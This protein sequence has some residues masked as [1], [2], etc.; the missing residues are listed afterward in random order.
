M[1]NITYEKVLSAEVG[2]HSIE[3]DKTGM[4]EVS[5]SYANDSVLKATVNDL[6]EENHEISEYTIKEYDEHGAAIH[7]QI[8]ASYPDGVL[9]V[10]KTYPKLYFRIFRHIDGGDEELVKTIGEDHVKAFCRGEKS[11]ADE[12]GVMSFSHLLANEQALTINIS[13]LPQKYD[14]EHEYTYVIKE[15][16]PTNQTNGND[17]IIQETYIDNGKVYLT[18]KKNNIPECKDMYFKVMRDNNAVKK[19]VTGTKELTASKFTISKTELEGDFLKATGDNDVS[20]TNTLETIDV[21]VAKS[22]DDNG[23]GVESDT[24]KVSETSEKLHY[25]VKVTLSGDNITI[26][27]T[28]TN[29]KIIGIKDKDSNLRFESLPKYVDENTLAVY[30]VKEDA[31]NDNA[32]YGQISN[33]YKNEG[34]TTTLFTRSSYRYG[35]EGSCKLKTETNGNMQFNILNTLPLTAVKVQKHWD[36]QNNQFKLRPSNINDKNKGENTADSIYL[37]LSKKINSESNYADLKPTEIVGTNAHEAEFKDWYKSESNIPSSGNEWTYTYKKLLKYDINNN[38]YTFQITED[39]VPAYKEPHYCAVSDYNDDSKKTEK[40]KVTSVE[41]NN[42][43]SSV[44]AKQLAWDGTNPLVEA[45]EITNKLDT[46]NVRV[47]KKWEDNGYENGNNLHYNVKITLSSTDITMLAGGNYSENKVIANTDKNGV[48]FANVP[49]YKKDGTTSVVYKVTEYATNDTATV[50]N[51]P[52]G[53][54]GQISNAYNDAGTATTDKFTVG[55]KRYGYVGSCKLETDTN[56]N[57]QFNILN[58]LPLTAVKVEKEWDDQSNKF[59]LRPEDIADKLSI[60]HSATSSTSDLDSSALGSQIWGAALSATNKDYVTA[61]T[62]PSKNSNKW[63]Y[64]YTKLLKYDINNHPYLFKVTETKVNAYKDPVY[65]TQYLNYIDIAPADTSTNGATALTKPLEVKNTLDTKKVTVYKNWVDKNYTDTNTLHYD[66]TVGL[67]ASYGKYVENAQHE[68]VI[69]SSN[70]SNSDTITAGAESCEFVNLPVYDANG[71]A[72]SYSA[73]ET[74]QQYGYESS[75][76]GGVTL[77]GGDGSIT[78]TNTLPLVSFTAQKEWDDEYN[79]DKVRPT[80]VTFKLQRKISTETSWTDVASLNA[81]Q[82]N[83]WKVDF[84]KQRK[85]DAQNNEYSYQIVEVTPAQYSSSYVKGNPTARTDD[86][87]IMNTDYTFTNKYDITE[88]QLTVKKIWNDVGYKDTIRPTDLSKIKVELWC[89][90]MNSDGTTFTDHKVSE[91][92]TAIIGIKTHIDTKIAQ[93]ET[94]LYEP[95]LELDTNN[96]QAVSDN[97]STNGYDESQYESTHVFTHLPVYINVDGTATKPGTPEKWQ[98][99]TYYVKETFEVNGHVYKSEYSADNTNYYGTASGYTGDGKT[100]TG[101]NLLTTPSNINSN[102]AD[103]TIYVKNTPVTRD[104]LVTKEWDDNGYGVTEGNDKVSDL[105]KKLHYTTAVTLKGTTTFDNGTTQTTVYNDNTKYIAAEAFAANT[106]QGVVFKNVPIYDKNGNV[107]VYKVTESKTNQ[108]PSTG[109]DNIADVGS[110]NDYATSNAGET[111]FEQLKADTSQRDYG[112]EGSA[113]KY[114]KNDSGRTYT[115]RYHITDVLPLT[116]VQVKKHWLDQNNEFNLRPSNINDKNKGETV[117][118]SIDLTI[119]RKLSTADD[120]TYTD[121][122]PTNTDTYKEDWY[123]SGTKDTTTTVKYD[124]NNTSYN[125]KITEASVKAYEA[126]QYR[127]ADDY[128]KTSGYTDK[129]K[130]TSVDELSSGSTWDGNTILKQTF[131]ITNKLDTIEVIVAKS[132]QD[133]DCENGNDLHYNVKVTLSSD[134]INVPSTY[135][136]VKVIEN[137]DKNGVKFENLPRYKKDGTTVVSYKVQEDATDDT[138]SLEQIAEAYHTSGEDAGN[139][140]TC[141]SK[142]YGYFGSCTLETDS[143]TGNMQ[144]NILNTLPVT[145][146]G[147]TKQWT[148]NALMY[149]DSLNKYRNSPVSLTLQQKNESGTYINFRTKDVAYSNSMSAEFDKLPVY[150]SANNKYV[151]K[152]VENPLEGYNATY[153]PDDG[154]ITAAET[155]TPS[156]TVTNTQITG[157]ATVIK[158]DKTHYDAYSN[159]TSGLYSDIVIPGAKFALTYNNGTPV[160]VKQ[161]TDKS[162]IPDVNGNNIVESGDDGKIIFK[163]FP[164]NTYTLTETE[165]PQGFLPSGTPAVFT[166]DVNSGTSTTADKVTYDS[167]FIQGNSNVKNRIGNLQHVEETKITLV[168]EDATDTKIQLPNATYYFLQMKVYEYYHEEGVNKEQYIEAADNALKECKGVLTDAVKEYWQTSDEVNGELISYIYTTDSNGMIGPITGIM[169]GRYAFVEVQAPEGYEWSY[170]EPFEITSDN[171]VVPVEHKDPRKAVSL[172]ILKEDKYHN[173]L[174]GGIFELWYKPDV[175]TP[176]TYSINSP[177]TSPIPSQTIDSTN[178]KPAIPNAAQDTVQHH[179]VTYSYSEMGTVPTAESSNWVLP[180]TD[181]DYI[182]FED[183][184][185][186]S[187][188]HWFWKNNTN[189]VTTYHKDSRGLTMG[190]LNNESN[191]DIVAEFFSDSNGTN[192]IGKYKVWERFVYYTDSGVTYNASNSQSPSTGRTQNIIWKIQ[193][194]DG[195]KS[196]RFILGWNGLSNSTKV[197]EF[198]KGNLYRRNNNGS[199]QSVTNAGVWDNLGAKSSEVGNNDDRTAGNSGVAYKALPQK[200]IF[201][202]NHYYCWDNIHI[203][204]FKQTGTDTYEPVGERFPGYMMEPYAYAKADYRIEFDDRTEN[205]GDLCYEIAIP[206]GA[207]HFRI[208]NGTTSTHSSNTSSDYYKGYGYYYTAITEIDFSAESANKKN[209]NNYWKFDSDSQSI[210]K[211]GTLTRWTENE[212]T[213]GNGT[214]HDTVYDNNATAFEV[215]SDHD[216]IYFTKPSSWDNVYAYFYGGGDLRQDNWQRAIWSIWPGVLPFNS[217]LQYDPTNINGSNVFNDNINTVQLLPGAKFKN[218]YNETVYRFKRPLGDNRNYTKVIF[219]NGLV[220]AGTAIGNLNGKETN[221]ITYTLGKGYYAY[222]ENASKTGVGEWTQEQSNSTIPYTFRTSGGTVDYIYIKNNATNSWDD[223]HIKFYNG[224]TQ[225]L[226]QNTGYVMK[227]TGKLNGEDTEWYKVPVPQN[228]TTFS[229]NNGNDKS[230]STVNNSKSTAKY[231]ILEYSANPTTSGYT[232]TGSMV[233]QIADTPTS[234]TTYALTLC[235]PTMTRTETESTESNEQV[236]DA[237]YISRGD[238]LNIVDMNNGWSLSNKPQI[239]FYDENNIKIGEKDFYSGIMSKAENSGTYNGKHWWSLDIPSAATS[240][241]INGDGHYQIYP[242]TISNSG[243]EDTT[244]T[245]GGMYYK[246]TGANTAEIIWPTFTNGVSSG[247]GTGNYDE[248]G[249]YLYL[250][251]GQSNNWNNM[252]VTFYSDEKGENV[253]SNADNIQMKYTGSLSKATDGTIPEDGK[254]TVIPEAVGHWY[255]AAIPYSAKSFKVYDATSSP[256]KQLDKAYPIYT[257]RTKISP[258]KDDYTLG[259]MQYRISDSESAGVYTLGLASAYNDGKPFYPNF[260][261]NEVIEWPEGDSVPTSSETTT[262]DPTVVGEYKSASVVPI[263]QS[264]ASEPD[265]MPVLYDT[266]TATSNE[267]V[268]YSWSDGNPNYDYIRFD[269]GELGSS[270]YSWGLVEDV[271]EAHFFNNDSDKNCDWGNEVSKMTSEGNGIWKIAIPK[272][273]DNITAKYQYVIFH[274]SLYDGDANQTV[275]IDLSRYGSGGFGYKFL[276]LTAQDGQKRKVSVSEPAGEPTKYLKFINNAGWTINSGEYIQAKFL[277]D[278]NHQIGTTVNMTN[279][280]VNTWQFDMS[281]NENPYGSATKVVFSNNGSD[282]QKVETDL[283]GIAPK[284]GWGYTF[285][286]KNTGYLYV[287]LDEWRNTNV[288]VIVRSSSHGNSNDNN[289]LTSAINWDDS[290]YDG[291]NRKISS[292]YLYNDIYLTCD[293]FSNTHTI[294]VTPVAGEVWKIKSNL[295]WEKIKTLGGNFGGDWSEQDITY[296]VV[297]NDGNTKSATYQPEDRYS[298]ISNLTNTTGNGNDYNFITINTGIE[299]PYIKFY[300]TTDGTGNVIGGVESGINLEDAKLNGSSTVGTKIGDNKYRIR[301]PKNAKSFAVGDGTNYSNATVL[302]DSKE[303]TYTVTKDGSAVTISDTTDRIGLHNGADISI[304]E[305]TTDFDYIYFTDKD[306]WNSNGSKTIYA[307]YYGGIDGEYNTWPGVPAQKVYTDNSGKSVYVFQPPKQGSDSKVYPYVIFNN[308]SA[309]DRKI[310]QKIEYQMGYN[311]TPNDTTANYGTKSAYAT[312]DVYKAQGRPDDND[313]NSENQTNTITLSDKYIFFVNNG[314]KDLRAGATGRYKLD[315]VHIRFFDENN[316]P[317]GNTAGYKMYELMAEYEGDEVYRVRIPDS[318]KKFQITNGIG[319]NAANS[320]YNNYRYSEVKDIKENGLYR[321]VRSA[322]NNFG[323]NSTSAYANA[324]G[325]NGTVTIQNIGTPL[326]YLELLNEEKE[327]DDGLIVI[328]GSDEPVY[329][330]TVETGYDGLTKWIT[331]LRTKTVNG[332]EVVDDEYLKNTLDDIKN[333][334]VT[335]VKVKK[336][337]KYFWKE[338][339]APYGY[340]IDVETLPTFK[341]GAEESELAAY[342]QSA[343][344]SPKTGAVQLTKTAKEKVGNTDI[345]NALDGF[346]FRLYDNSDI[347]KEIKL[348][349]KAGLQEYYVYP[350]NP[351]QKQ[352]EI[353]SKMLSERVDSENDTSD[354]VWEHNSD[355]TDFEYYNTGDDSNSPETDEHGQIKIENIPWGTY[356]L[357]EV[358]VK[359]NSGYVYTNSNADKSDNRNKVYFTVGRNNCLDVQELSCTDEMQPAYI[360]LFE[361]INMKKEAWGD[362]TFIFKIKQTANYINGAL[363]DTDGKEMLV[364]LTVNEDNEV[365]TQIVEKYDSNGEIKFTADPLGIDYANWLVEGTTESEYKGMYHID[366]EGRIRVE[367]GKYEITRMPVSRYEFVADTWKL[368]DDNTSNIYETHKHTEQN[369]TMTGKE[370]KVEVTIPASK[371]AMVHYYDKVAYYDKFSEVQENINT[372]YSLDNDNKHETIKGIR[373]AEYHVDKTKDDI[374]GDDTLTVSLTDN[375]RFKAYMVL[376]DGSERAMTDDE[377]KKLGISYTYKTHDDKNFGSYTDKTKNDFSYDNANDKIKVNNSSRY[378]DE[379][380]TL[381][382]KYNSYETDFELIMAESDKPKTLYTRQV[383]FKSDIVNGVDTPNV[384]YFVDSIIHDSV[385]ENPEEIHTGEYEFTFI[386]LDDETKETGDTDKIT[387][388]DVRHNGRSIGKSNEW[389]TIVNKLINVSDGNSA[390]EINESFRQG[391]GLSIT[392]S[393]ASWLNTSGENLTASYDD[394]KENIMSDLND[395]SPIVFTAQLS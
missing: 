206:K 258:Y 218:K 259:G 165:A 25:N 15:W 132:W 387:V 389:E 303:Y 200:I 102:P 22:W 241:T 210:K 81:T 230:S 354:Y 304:L 34:E 177:V 379:I 264:T 393:F 65:P 91:D 92:T 42:S 202:R 115:S 60:Y 268:T 246:T 352:Q 56:G 137:T 30:K 310:T 360:R 214:I 133:N 314:T 297:S 130:V 185:C 225:I 41:I 101:T 220:G 59:N 196:V 75:I 373:I 356:Y 9:T 139:K 278:E 377:I 144:F 201:R 108:S 94:Y 277:D 380:Y 232:K 127:I 43:E 345:G 5:K 270:D 309:S 18:V 365:I 212:I 52:I 76:S 21:V 107:I 329:L 308:G 223:I 17:L 233:Y 216:F 282:S 99:V 180:R 84:G 182:F 369:P 299:K 189:I 158:V 253:I 162:Y 106:P 192:S 235:S 254:T 6:P 371:T 364:A 378:N 161:D 227:Y 186:Y 79:R 351:T 347:R 316:N 140:F 286:A 124:A 326:Y 173:G 97:A 67:A 190:E 312:D 103:K 236:N 213:K 166:I 11:E 305:P 26:P 346:K 269:T 163:N 332:K 164:L 77:T 171:K 283:Q 64:T 240:F 372:F 10:T 370:P 392:Y 391:S 211:G 231:P 208:N 194:P 1:K 300:A 273:D 128:D 89:R 367:P 28:Y 53:E 245:T 342:V 244:F 174:E 100:I 262:I 343:T 131:D 3:A 362:P 307:Y 298:Y 388:Y 228:A 249:D 62:F 24:A 359:E 39:Q 32:S 301:L 319:K 386:I 38:A 318:A 175:V 336:W 45:F 338:I 279:I 54:R 169:E 159:H 73:T 217:E 384:S 276:G 122:H 114:T 149:D 31:T 320:T 366:D 49:R 118:D 296:P 111:E 69:Q 88:K 82:D 58:T 355:G 272:K 285:T 221:V 113:V 98:A 125:F 281:A 146:I 229:L 48:E 78:I 339:E 145:K 176:P 181:N 188:D 209:Y 7:Q 193:P 243:A 36:D 238:K 143:V 242:K 349:R 324:N 322:V 207:T 239:R 266:G 150:D 93:G 381:T 383:V 4:I 350:D 19:I 368:E 247:S 183:V 237:D 382:A 95:T 250:V 255:K 257:K 328:G 57:M 8:E 363:T 55:S 252:Y 337:G 330:A 87:S 261:E 121:I 40:Q 289:Y 353:L 197:F 224:S 33:A 361:H 291:Y 74:G 123:K 344:D 157:G 138:A 204:F 134:N 47:A 2:I 348:V 68:L 71:T 256:T 234:D 274:R 178:T 265:D 12:N 222:N 86:S 184:D 385:E 226:Q 331:A 112:Y 72:I 66:I 116:A 284:K 292:D 375:T 117:T 187:A 395:T 311:Y 195:A 335:E 148:Y 191:T 44:V 168:K 156:V 151:Y 120:N 136:N 203:E 153:S 288:D 340:E 29:E 267:T 147:V 170:C 51:Q 333:T 83:N 167:G 160:K 119:S 135:N 260:T 199:Q 294:G 219:S 109:T 155:A 172:K 325:L 323:E 126:C 376:A 198:T 374:S 275:D 215:E 142:R 16:N 306:S 13:N 313:T 50:E 263:P 287:V 129:Q 27:N 280:S 80:S 271:I 70:Y 61:A 23:Y 20:V 290:G 251:C 110:W 96:F 105:S 63:T 85:Y 327:S 293:G 14:D 321:F 358:A 154:I 152:V 390:F 302:D 90:Y 334:S 394:I 37:T 357:E 315:D 46:I 248:R 295:D 104:F 179:T 141:G 35:Y 205:A 341:V 317:I